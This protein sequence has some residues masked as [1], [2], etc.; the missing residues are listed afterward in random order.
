MTWN[1]TRTWA[2]GDI[3][4]AA[5]ANAILRDD[6]QYNRDTYREV[7]NTKDGVV[8][9]NASSTAYADLGGTTFL[10]NTLVKR[11][12]DSSLDVELYGSASM[13]TSAGGCRFG[14]NIGGTDYD[15]NKFFFNL[16]DNHETFFSM[17]SVTG[18]AAGTYTVTAR[19]KSLAGAGDVYIN[20]GDGLTMHISEGSQD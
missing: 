15:G 9:N 7:V 6:V 16:I 2:V 3:F 13:G 20:T 10:S 12:A 17:V 18:L 1:A 4:V 5:D 19:V 8:W 11:Q 14:A